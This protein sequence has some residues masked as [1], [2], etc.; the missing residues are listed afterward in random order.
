MDDT[1]RVF[2][3]FPGVD[4]L[5]ACAYWIGVSRKCAWGGSRDEDGR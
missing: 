3:L 1:D 4:A 2:Q 5:H